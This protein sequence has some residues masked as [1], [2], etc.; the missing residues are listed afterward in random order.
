VVKDNW[1][2]KPSSFRKRR[3]LGEKKTT[4]APGK[5]IAEETS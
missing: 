2:W 3:A 1:L 4:N 5:K